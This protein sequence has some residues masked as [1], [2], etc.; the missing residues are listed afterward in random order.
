MNR[1]EI[2]LLGGFD[3]RLGGESVIHFETDAARALLAYLALNPGINFARER[4]A[5]LLWPENP[6]DAAL[7]NLRTTLHRLRRAIGEEAASSG[8]LEITRS[9]IKLEEK[10]NYWLDVNELTALLSAIREH[11]HRRPSACPVCLRRMERVVVLYREGLLPDFEL[12]SPA[13]SAWLFAE[14]EGLRRQVMGILQDLWEYACRRGEYARAETYLRKQ[15]ELEPWLEEAHQRLMRLLAMKGERSAA[16][17]QYRTCSDH[18]KETFDV[19]PGPETQALYEAIISGYELPAHTCIAVHTN[20]LPAQLTSFVGR[21]YELHQLDEWLT[22]PAN[23]LVTLAGL[24]GV[25]KTRLALA[26]AQEMVGTFEHGV[27][28]IPL[29]D[30]EDALAPDQKS[31][32]AASA[33][34]REW[35]IALINAMSSAFGLNFSAEDDRGA[36][37]LNYLRGREMLLLIDRFE[38]MVEAGR[39]FI[40]SVLRSSPRICVLITS[41]RRLNLQAERF[42]EL[43]GLPVPEPGFKLSDLAAKTDAGYASLR[44][45]AERAGRIGRPFV[46]DESNL[47]GVIEICRLV[48]GMPLAIELAAARASRFS[49]TQISQAV[50]ADLESL[51]ATLHDLPSR[52]RSVRLVFE[53]SW[54]LLSQAERQALARLAVFRSGFDALAAWEIAQAEPE[55]I[56]SL[57]D[58]SLL[59]V[60]PDGQLDM[61][62]LLRQFAAERL[63]ALGIIGQI[64]DRYCVYYLGFLAEREARL[65][66]EQ[67]QTALSEI[68]YEWENIRYAWELAAEQRRLSEL[69]QALRSLT[70]FCNLKGWINQCSHMTGQA[71]EALNRLAAGSEKPAEMSS[72]KRLLSR[73]FLA[74]AAMLVSLGNDIQGEALCQQAL[75]LIQEIPDSQ[76]RVEAG[77]LLSALYRLQGR[78]ESA[79]AQITDLLSGST[80]LLDQRALIYHE[81][82][83]IL[84]AQGSMAEA[85]NNFRAALAIYEQISDAIGRVK[86]INSLAGVSYNR[87]RLE[88]A[89][90]YSLE[91]LELARRLGDRSGE[92]SALSNLGQ[93]YMALGDKTKSKTYLETALN[94]SRELGDRQE[95]AENLMLLGQFWQWQGDLQA[96]WRLLQEARDLFASMGRLHWEMEALLLLGE[97][98][99]QRGDGQLA[100]HALHTS[101][102]FFEGVRRPE[103]CVHSYAGLAQAALQD[104]RLD[105]AL[106]MVEKALPTLEDGSSGEVSVPFSVHLAVIQVLQEIQDGRAAR[107]LSTTCRALQNQANLIQDTQLRESFLHQI[108][109]HCQILE[110]CQNAQG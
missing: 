106:E 53:S 110:L 109:C 69:Q 18:L 52:H 40:L 93:A 24:G 57:V 68:L 76:A 107:L 47:P 32:G 82:G 70:R 26:A 58:Q 3:V 95:E 45:F 19:A 83:E 11:I 28:W 80:L 98:Y 23:R 101:L 21:E 36:R 54:S 1:L 29:A 8:L 64:N 9:T 103:R 66:G 13:F 79:I 25:G 27:W 104:G 72:V 71:S 2:S 73:L 74:Q 61:H 46:L 87:G 44:L 78:F 43:S 90:N 50:R 38:H 62:E 81:Q 15:L 108:T 65:H 33:E 84:F 14:R 6:F 91:F 16:L 67:P 34:R 41:R 35:P 100:S 77:L 42:L 12:D 99:L 60:A 22:N 86:V 55:I 7:T 39:G 48:E 92:A 88:E 96:A 30:S 37:L 49:P 5:G 20:N 17:M 51:S 85:E 59:R 10:S 94:L 56:D 31:V 4:I 89:L 75:A 97:L 102:E 63:K 105:V